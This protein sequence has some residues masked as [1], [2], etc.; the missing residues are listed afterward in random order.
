MSG[1][2]GIQWTDA[3]WNPVRG[4]SRISPGCENC[5]AETMAARFSAPGAWAHGFALQGPAR[6]TR[7]VALVPSALDLPLRWK[8]PRRIFVN[9]M[10]DLFH[11]SL[12]N[13]DIAAV[14]GVMAA[15][16]QHTFQIL[17]KRAERMVKWFEWARTSFEQHRHVVERSLTADHLARLSRESIVCAHWAGRNLPATLMADGE[18]AADIIESR[19]PLPNV[20]LGVSVE[21][22]ARADERIPHLLRAPAA[23]RFLSV[24]PLLGPVDLRLGMKPA[25]TA[26]PGSPPLRGLVDW[27][28]VGGESGHGARTMR[29]EWARRIVEQCKAAGVACFVKQLGAAPQSGA[30]VDSTWPTPKDRKGGD[31]DEWPAD[32]RVRD[33]PRGAP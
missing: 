10:S 24:E 18:L 16:P 33:F 6:W 15:C 26:P 28:I 20:W 27:V 13:E 31:M 23:V 9:S 21:D 12:S 29:L 7:K 14:F 3:T 2:T 4:C 32:L 1:T 17:T 19:W 8:K 11:E 30:T 22:Q 5:Y 25:D